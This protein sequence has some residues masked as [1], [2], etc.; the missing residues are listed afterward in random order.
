M[1]KYASIQTAVRR[2]LPFGRDGLLLLSG[3]FLIA[4]GFSWFLAPN[5]IASGGVQG[6]SIIVRKLWN[7]E[8]AWTQ[9]VL[10]VPL[11]VAGMIWLGKKYS[12][13]TLIGS[14]ILPGFVYLTAEGPALTTQPLLA[15]V[16]GGLIVGIGVGLV[17]RGQCSTGGLDIAAQIL[18]KYAHIRLG[19][20]VGICDGIVILAV[21]VVF[22]VEQALYAWIGLYVMSVTIDKV[23]LGFG[24]ARVAFVI[25]DQEEEIATAILQHLDRGVTR[26]VAQGAFT[27]KPRVVLLTVVA[28]RE[29]TPLKL[30]VQ[31][32]DPRAFL[33]FTP[34]T[35]VRGEGF[36]EQT[37]SR[38]GRRMKTAD[39]P[40][41][42]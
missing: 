37:V 15:T 38:A 26:F 1:E 4:I 8:P 42:P 25:S 33:I 40:R 29:V 19:V 17:F 32:I 13:K 3:T 14:L 22:G 36:G 28:L 39:V 12:I 41:S 10:N 24:E 20:A 23:Q 16:Y 7:I 21:A 30:L 35:E 31:R 11:F 18:A 27:A 5:D 34:A 6:I 9:W 2:H